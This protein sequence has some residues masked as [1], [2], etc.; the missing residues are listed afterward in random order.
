MIKISRLLLVVGLT[1]V[2]AHAVEPDAPSAAPKAPTDFVSLDTDGDGRISLAEFTAP[3]AKLR[4]AMQ[5]PPAKKAVTAEGDASHDGILSAAD[6]I[7]GRYSPVVFKQLDIDHDD[8][9]SPT[10]LE[11]LFASAH[12]ISQP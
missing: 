8:Y 2:A 7:E 11:A 6:S 9:L 12:N 3:A 4:D 5:P 10:E 1:A